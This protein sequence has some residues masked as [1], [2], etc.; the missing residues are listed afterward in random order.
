MM[1]RTGRITSSIALAVSALSFATPE[2]GAPDAASKVAAAAANAS[3]YVPID[4]CRLADTRQ[5]LGF[6]RVDDSTSRIDTD[7][8]GIPETATSLIVS[9]TI[10]NPSDRGWLVVYPSGRERQT[11]ATLNWRPRD[12]RA[13]TAT[14]AI[15]DDRHVTV[16]RTGSFDDGAVIVDVVGAFVP[17]TEAT[18]GR[19]VPESTARRLLDTR[20]GARPSA[21]STVTIPLPA[22]VPSDASAVSVN[23]TAVRN[24]GGGFVSAYPAG[25]ERPDTSVLNTDRAGQFRAAAT[26]VPVTSEGFELYVS[27]ATHLIVDITGWFTGGSAPESTDGLFV[28]V[29]PRR[30]RDTRLEP[31]PIHRDG[32]IEVAVPPMGDSAAVAYSVTIIAPGMNGYITTHAARTPRGPT[33]SGY[34]QQEDL[35]AQFGISAMSA[36]GVA[37]YSETGSEIT[38]DLLGYFTGSAATQTQGAP[39]NVTDRQRVIAIGD[40]SLAGIDRNR[41]WAQLRGADFDLRARSC[42]RLARPSCRG[43]EGPIPPPTVLQEIWSLPL[44]AF[45]V[46]VIMAGYN[47]SA[48]NVRDAIPQILD[49]A[50]ARGIDH[51]IWLT[52]SREFTSD[53][54]GSI[55]GK[56]VY[57]DHNVAI[58][59]AAA[60][61]A[62][63]TAFEWG[64]V[65]RQ[66][67]FWL[68]A[69]G[70]HL[71]RYGGHGAADFISRAVAHVAGQR[72]PVPVFPGA[73]NVGV[74][75]DPGLRSPVDIAALYGV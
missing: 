64:A 29:N 61:N 18:S 65:T 68:Y 49:A 73:V 12:I 16:H 70:L 69:D 67:P 43:R 72:C 7:A 63:M 48:N 27:A 59:D 26:I 52:H 31:E 32:T 4:P 20:S 35:T 71:D 11:A 33:S 58:R 55:P 56:Q 28:S 47:G 2:L 1:R 36:R 9:T 34:G 22:G 37:L 10:A 41:A 57:A 40:S 53:K 6:V 44:G 19:L 66:A 74:C 42:R 51:V 62:D 39:R 21:G 46:A 60:A 15:G 3:A 23:V 45:D 75:P 17:A 5:G 24:E 30:L 8:C 25:T 50:R 38:F 13:N 54:G 14:V